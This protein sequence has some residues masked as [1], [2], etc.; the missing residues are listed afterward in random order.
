MLDLPLGTRERFASHVVPDGECLAWA[1]YRDADGYGVLQVGGA[2]WRAHRLAW[3]L[4]NDED[5]G[6]WL[7]LHSCHHPWCVN[8]AHL[9]LGTHA[10]N[11]ADMVER[12]REHQLRLNFA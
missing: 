5:P 9:R 1:A 4:A 10:E 2:H 6:R 8:P 11:M 7:V 3:A 12:R